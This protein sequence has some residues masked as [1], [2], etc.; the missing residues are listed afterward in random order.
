MLTI[1]TIW[2]QVFMTVH[3]QV[4]YMSYLF[5]IYVYAHHI[6]HLDSGPYGNRQS[7][8]VQCSQSHHKAEIS[9]RYLNCCLLGVLLALQVVASQYL[10]KY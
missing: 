10:D 1:H 6:Y 5:Y 4:K 2:T 8:N 7:G 9:I 3:N